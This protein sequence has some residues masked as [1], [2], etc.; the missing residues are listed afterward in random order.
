MMVEKIRILF[1]TSKLNV[2][3]V[4]MTASSWQRLPPI[5][6]NPTG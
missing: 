3:S 6:A 1:E 5:G 2:R 4:Q